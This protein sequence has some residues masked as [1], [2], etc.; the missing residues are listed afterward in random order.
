MCNIFTLHKFFSNAERQAEVRAGCTTAGIGCIDC[1]KMLFEGLKA[2]LGRIRARAEALRANPARVDEILAPAP[3]RARWSPRDHGARARAARAARRP[4]MKRG[5]AGVASGRVGVAGRA[6]GAGCARATRARARVGGARRSS[7]RCARAI[8]AAVYDRFGPRT[9]AHIEELLVA[10]APDR[11]HAHAAPAGSGDRRL[12]AAG[13]GAGRHAHARTATATRPRSRSTRRPAIARRCTSCARARPGRS[14]CRC[15]DASRELK[16]RRPPARSPRTWV[17][18]TLDEVGV[19][20]LD[21][22]VVEVGDG[23]VGAGR[24]RRGVARRAAALAHPALA[25][26]NAAVEA[27]VA[28]IAVATVAPQGLAEPSMVAGRSEA[29]DAPRSRGRSAGCGSAAP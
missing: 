9:R 14:S 23:Q 28:A 26:E 4:A 19:A 11:R 21:D 29:Q 5:G 1:K 13:L 17:C 3:P 10:G 15:A 2:D 27:V 24:C 6:G 25:R 16:S 20:E 8:A 12:G 18:S 22:H 7:P